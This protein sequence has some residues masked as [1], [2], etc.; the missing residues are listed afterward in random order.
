MDHLISTIV[1]L[2]ERSARFQLCVVCFGRLKT[3][4]NNCRLDNLLDYIFLMRA[5]IRALNR[6]ENGN[7]G[8]TG[9][10]ENGVYIEN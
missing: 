7:M 6:H 5:M 3:L 2:E 9:R 1:S 10:G 8:G 4:S